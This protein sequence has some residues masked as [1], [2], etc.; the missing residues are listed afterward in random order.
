MSSAE[1]SPMQNIT[2]P[3]KMVAGIRRTMLQMFVCVC[4]CVGGGVGGCMCG[5]FETT[6]EYYS[7]IP[8][9]PVPTKGLVGSGN[10]AS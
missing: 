2:T 8:G 9:I 3:T 7:L 4:V 5:T 1:A 10:E 6:A